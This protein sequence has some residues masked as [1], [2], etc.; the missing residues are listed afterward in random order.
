M[1]DLNG[2]SSSDWQV[3]KKAIEALLANQQQDLPQ[4]LLTII[5]QNHRD[6]SALNAALQT[7]SL[8]SVPVLDGLIELIEDPLA[9]VRAYAILAL[10]EQRDPRAVPR[11]AKSSQRPRS[12]RALQRHRGTGKPKVYR[13]CAPSSGNHSTA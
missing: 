8:L 11:P 1:S 6:L 5:R 13:S 3:R 12:Q 4:A 10:G 9:E 2:L 7:L